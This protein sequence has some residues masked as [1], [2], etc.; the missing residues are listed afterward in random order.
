MPPRWPRKP[1]REDPDYRRLEDRMNFALHTA[2]CIAVNS[3]LWFFHTLNP[4]WVT[5]VSWLTLAWVGILAA[6]GIYIFV[7]ADYSPRRLSPLPNP[8]EQGDS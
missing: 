2:A 7:L 3:G 5:W 6:H 4:S 1:T 8:N